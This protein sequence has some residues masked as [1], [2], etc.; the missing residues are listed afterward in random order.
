MTKRFSKFYGKESIHDRDKDPKREP[1][2]IE[3]P[4]TIVRGLDGLISVRPRP[5]ILDK[6]IAT[7]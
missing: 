2:R 5:P 1:R 3:H 7:V 6:N 4:P